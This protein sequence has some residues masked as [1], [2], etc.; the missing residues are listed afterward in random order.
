[1]FCTRFSHF[2]IA[3]KMDIFMNRESTNC[4]WKYKAKGQ[5][6]FIS[7]SDFCIL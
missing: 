6:V 1:M 2:Y 4:R 3:A 7:I 5:T